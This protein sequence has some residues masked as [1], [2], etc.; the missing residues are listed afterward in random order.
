RIKR[1]RIPAGPIHR[2]SDDGRA[3]I[4]PGGGVALARTRACRWGCFEW[5]ALFFCFAFG[6]FLC[7]AFTRASAGGGVVAVGVV[8]LVVAGR[9]VIGT[10]PTGWP[11][12]GRRMIGASL[13]GSAVVTA[14]RLLWVVPTLRASKLTRPSMRAAPLGV[15]R[16]VRVL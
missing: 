11:N 1:I 16:P 9:L 2:P 15:P 14:A 8:G 5:P 3:R 7:P 12:T 6:P 4:G 13:P 10:V